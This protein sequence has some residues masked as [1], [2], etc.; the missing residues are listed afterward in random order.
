[1]RNPVHQHLWRNWLARSAVN[2]KVGGSSPPRCAFFLSPLLLFFP[3]ALRRFDDRAPTGRHKDS[4]VA[5]PSKGI[6]QVND[7]FIP[8]FIVNQLN[9]ST[10][11]SITSMQAVCHV[12]DGGLCQVRNEG[13]ET[14]PV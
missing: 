8:F 7:R 4:R 6:R 11:N 1:M 5:R 3:G 9:A 2:R 14:W 13:N 10:N 12:Q